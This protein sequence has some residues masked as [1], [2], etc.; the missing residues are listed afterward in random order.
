MSRKPILRGLLLVALAVLGGSHRA[1]ADEGAGFGRAGS[2]GAMAYR[3][4]G[5]DDGADQLTITSTDLVD[6]LQ[7]ALEL[8][9][10]G[11]VLAT[12]YAQDARTSG[13]NPSAVFLTAECVEPSVAGGC[14][15]RHGHP[16]PAPRDEPG[17]AQQ[18]LLPAEQP[19]RGNRHGDR[20]LPVTAPRPLHLQGP[21]QGRGRRHPRHQRPGPHHPGLRRSPLLVRPLDGIRPSALSNRP[22][23][24]WGVEPS[25]RRRRRE[26]P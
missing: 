18:P 3:T 25:H 10:T 11:P 9:C 12:F 21:G 1:R 4:L 26:S 8:L 6:V 15:P 19:G 23:E 2:C 5:V 24:E 22:A 16:D 14:V 20:R 13:G 7:A 17:R